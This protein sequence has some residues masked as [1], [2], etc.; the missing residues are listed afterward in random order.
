MVATPDV[1]MD[2]VETVEVDPETLKKEAD[3]ATIQEIREHTKQIEK[4]VS[5]KEPR[6]I[7]RVLRSLPNT[8]RKLNPIVLR[9]LAAQLYPAG[10]EREGILTF[11]EDMPAGSTEPEIT[12]PRAAIKTPLPEVVAYFHLLSLVKLLDANLLERASNC[13]TYFFD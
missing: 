1:E 4:A 10:S 2:T 8:R 3:L 7:L 9:A 12:R 11:V 5:N 6:F 13:G